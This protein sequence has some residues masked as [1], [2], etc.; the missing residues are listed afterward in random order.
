MGSGQGSRVSKGSRCDA[1]WVYHQGNTSQ[2]IP[3][4]FLN[5]GM[6]RWWITMLISSQYSTSFLPQFLVRD[7]VLIFW[8]IP[9]GVP[10]NFEYSHELWLN[11]VDYCDLCGH[12]PHFL[13]PKIWPPNV[14]LPFYQVH[15]FCQ[16]L[17]CFATVSEELILW[18]STPR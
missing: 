3:K 13:S 11:D 12:L 15:C 6:A 9:Q 1:K 17:S 7:G 10:V 4:I 8:G 5:N 16:N 18:Q 14:E 2:G